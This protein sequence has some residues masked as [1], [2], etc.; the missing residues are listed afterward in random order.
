[1]DLGKLKNILVEW[2][3]DDEP[4]CYDVRW[5]IKLRT[6]QLMKLGKYEDKLATKNEDRIKEQKFYE[7]LKKKY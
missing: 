7:I 5:T 2:R 6:K 1:M 4:S 3:E